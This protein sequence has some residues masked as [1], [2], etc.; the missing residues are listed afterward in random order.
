M[1]TTT[2]ETFP[3]ASSAAAECRKAGPNKRRMARAPSGAAAAE[4][5]GAPNHS[6]IGE[7][8]T[9]AATKIASVI[10]LLQSE[11]GATLAEMVKAT[12]WL[13][14]TTRAALTGLKKKGHTL[15]KNKRDDMTCYRIAKAS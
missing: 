11:Q 1:N 15:S 13:P 6:H 2:T 10:A 8:S 14:H 12:G 7:T 3:Q 4:I 5:A 9:R